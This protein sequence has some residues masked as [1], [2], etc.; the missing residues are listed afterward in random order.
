MCKGLWGAAWATTLWGYAPIRMTL[1]IRRGF[2][3]G[4]ASLKKLFLFRFGGFAAK[5]EQKTGVR[6]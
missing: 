3:G 2:G 5:A 4:E 6:A 1:T